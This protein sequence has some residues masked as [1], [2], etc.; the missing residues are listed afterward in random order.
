M[1]IVVVIAGA[2]FMMN[3]AID[4]SQLVAYLLYITTLTIPISASCSLRS[5]SKEA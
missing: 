5:S 1:Y 4:P 3:G 2:I